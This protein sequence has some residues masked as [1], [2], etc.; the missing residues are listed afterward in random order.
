MI[1][2]DFSESSSSSNK[3]SAET[4]DEK[5]ANRERDNSESILESLSISSL[6]VESFFDSR[7]G[8]FLVDNSGVK[9][10][11]FLFKY[12]VGSLDAF[13]M[14]HHVSKIKSL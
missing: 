4:G 14:P 1:I 3:I 9:G 10:A 6:M 12:F 11:L 13:F 8:N 2:W 7:Q 5:A